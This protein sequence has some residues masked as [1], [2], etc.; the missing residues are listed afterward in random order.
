MGPGLRRDD[1]DMVSHS[2]GPMRP[3][4]AGNFPPPKI[5]RAQGMPDARCTRGLACNVHRKMRTR[6]YRFSGEHPTFPARWL[7]GLLRALPGEPSTFATVTPRINP[8]RLTP[9]S[10]RQDHTTSPYASAA[11][12]SRNSCVHRNPPL[13]V[14]MANAPLN[15]TG[16]L[17][18][19]RDLGQMK[20]E[21]F[22]ILGLDA[23]SENQN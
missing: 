9:A 12:V 1:V 22:S 20:T 19:C 3:R 10:G 18:M 15:G 14:T 7:Y 16:W 8:R 23:I 13:V 5:Q 2:R 4:L 11:I 17:L 21:I 6:A